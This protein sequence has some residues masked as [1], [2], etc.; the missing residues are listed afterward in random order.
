MS[1]SHFGGFM[2]KFSQNKLRWNQE[3]K[4]LTILINQKKIV[5]KIIG[6]D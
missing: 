2:P 3:N 6:Y 5:A 4:Y 1:P